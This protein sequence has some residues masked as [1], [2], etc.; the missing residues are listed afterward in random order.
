VIYLSVFLFFTEAVRLDSLMGCRAAR[1][2]GYG[3]PVPGAKALGRWERN[4]ERRRKPARHR[5]VVA[6][7][8]RGVVLLDLSRSDGSYPWRGDG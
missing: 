3:F 8:M 7:R 6:S 2:G 1:I 5:R 4:W